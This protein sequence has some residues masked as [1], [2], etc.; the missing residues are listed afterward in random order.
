MNWV[1]V[2][3]VCPVLACSGFVVWF[4]VLFGF[5]LCVFAVC[6]VYDDDGPMDY[7]QVLPQFSFAVLNSR[8]PGTLICITAHAM[9]YSVVNDLAKAM[10]ALDEKNVS[11]GLRN[12]RV[13][14]FGQALKPSKASQQLSKASAPHNPPQQLSKRPAGFAMV[15]PCAF[16]L[17]L[18]AVSIGL[19]NC[20]VARF[21][22]ALKPS[23]ASQ[24]LS[25]ASALHN[26]PQQLSKRPAGFAM[27]PPCVFLLALQAASIGL[28]NCRVARFVQA[29]KPSKASQQLSS[30]SAP[31]NP[32]QQLSKRP[33]CFA[34]VPPYWRQKL[35]LLGSET[36][37]WQSE[38]CDLL[39]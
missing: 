4:C 13:A 5:V 28:R 35:F 27:V 15:P 18:Q 29:L 23:K 33:A 12:C 10:K 14:R 11:I 8:W 2:I 19:R 37:A 22:Q 30:A 26:P 9:S 39:T 16:L 32:P 20:R 3:L 36:A 17:A 6:L 34:M 31:H 25:K 7:V 24:Q 21:G 38:G 1:P